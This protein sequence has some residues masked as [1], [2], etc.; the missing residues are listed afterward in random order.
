NLKDKRFADVRVRRAFAHA[1]NKRELLD[2][3]VLGLGREATGPFRPGTWA[4]NL[5]VKSIPYD[6]AR[7]AALLAEAGWTRN[8]TG[9]LEKDGQPFAFEL[10]TNQGNDERKKIAEIVQAALRELGV[11]VEIRV[12]EWAALL[13]EHVKKRRF[14]ALVLGWGTG[15]D[16]DQYVVW[17]SSQN[18]PDQL[19][20][21]SYD[22]PA[23]V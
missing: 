16:P 14:D 11:T 17:H 7:A 12:L 22:N 20:Q 1:I 15:A 13:K 9:V 5:A 6:P 3:V 19:K 4:D 2:G 23:V 8:G 10:L 21:I 18:G